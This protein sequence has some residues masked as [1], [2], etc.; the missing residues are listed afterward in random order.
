VIPENQEGQSS[1]GLKKL[2]I[3]IGFVELIILFGCIITLFVLYGLVSN[4]LNDTTRSDQ[5]PDLINAD[6]TLSPQLSADY[7]GTDNDDGEDLDTGLGQINIL[8]SVN[9]GSAEEKH[10]EKFCNRNLVAGVSALALAAVVI[11]LMI[12]G[13]VSSKPNWILPRLIIQIVAIFGLLGIVVLYAISCSW[14]DQEKPQFVLP[15]YYWTGTTISCWTILGVAS[16]ALIF[17]AIM[18]VYVFKLYM[19]SKKAG[20]SGNIKGRSVAS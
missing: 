8:Q 19:I 2:I 6:A 3:F 9:L 17:E 1:S 10:K 11:V 16:L 18:F 4:G 20:T 12:L 14:N 5:K 15:K 13:V 7:M